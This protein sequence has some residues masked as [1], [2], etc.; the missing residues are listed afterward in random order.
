MISS[1][2]THQVLHG[3]LRRPVQILL[4]EDSPSDVAMTLAALREGHI[5]NDI[6][7]AGDGEI[8]LDF[9]H[10][11]GKYRDAP[12]PDL[13]LLDLNLPKKDGREVLAEVKADHDLRAIPVVV[14]TTSTAESDVLRSYTLHANSYVRKPLGFEQ[15]LAVVQQIENFWLTLVRL[16]DGDGSSPRREQPALLATSNQQD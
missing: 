4:V 5:I 6:H 10:R 2:R 8:A 14:L 16:S 3:S 1:K 12:R 13:I 11:R 15:F 7:V 9:L